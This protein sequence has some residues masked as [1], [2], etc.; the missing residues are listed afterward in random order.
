MTE[1]EKVAKFQTEPIETIVKLLNPY[2]LIIDDDVI[3]AAS[4]IYKLENRQIT[5]NNQTFPYFL[6]SEMEQHRDDILEYSNKEYRGIKI[7]T[8]LTKDEIESLKH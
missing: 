5:I 7:P 8:K 4:T 1:E 3:S 2:L 6:F